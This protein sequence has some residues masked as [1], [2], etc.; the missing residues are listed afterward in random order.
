MNQLVYV[1]LFISSFLSLNCFSQI[2]F[3]TNREIY[4]FSVGDTFIYEV[5]DGGCAPQNSYQ[6]THDYWVTVISKSY[7]PDSSTVYYT[8][9]H[10]GYSTNFSLPDSFPNLDSAVILPPYATYLDNEIDTAYIDTL[11][12]C[13]PTF[14]AVKENRY[15]LSDFFNTTYTVGLGKVG[16]S[17]FHD[18]GSSPAGDFALDLVYYH[19]ATLVCGRYD[20]TKLIS[21]IPTLSPGQGLHLFPNPCHDKLYAN[22]GSESSTFVISDAM[23]RVYQS[24]TMSTAIPVEEL[25]AGLYYLKIDYG[26]KTAISKFSKE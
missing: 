9:N 11:H 26:T 17:Y 18:Q 4:N 23:G 22:V 20:S 19:K 24:G 12:Y 7:S 10:G 2:T 25:T 6:C 21:N 14:I 16:D 13:T 8:Y 5:Y 1:L 3:P 15:G